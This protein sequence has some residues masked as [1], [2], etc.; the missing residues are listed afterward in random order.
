MSKVKNKC[1]GC[2]GGTKGGGTIKPKPRIKS[3]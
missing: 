1:S 3:W 2:G